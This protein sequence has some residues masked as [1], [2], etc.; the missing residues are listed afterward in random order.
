MV[1][2]WIAAQ[3]AVFANCAG[4]PLV[5]PQLPSSASAI[6]RADYEYQTAAAYFY[7]TEYAEAARRFRQIALTQSSPW[8]RYGHYLAARAMIRHATVPDRSEAERDKLLE[9]AEAQLQEVLRDDS[10]AALHD[11]A[12]GLLGFVRARIRMT[13]RL[14]ELLRKLEREPTATRQDVE[15]YRWLSTRVPAGSAAAID[16]KSSDLADWMTTLQA[17]GDEAFGHALERW[18]ETTSTAWLVSALW[19]A[20]PGHQTVPQMMS[21]AA[22]ISRQS[23]AFATV[24]FLRVRL[25]LARGERQQARVLLATLPT[26][27]QPGFPEESINL[28]RAARMQLAATLDELLTNSVRTIVDPSLSPTGNHLLEDDAARVLTYQLPL[29]RLVDASRSKALPQRARFRIAVAALSRALVLRRDAEAREAAAVVSEVA[30]PF[31]DDIS[32]YL[33]AAGE[34][35]RHRLGLLLM[36]RHVGMHAYVPGRRDFGSSLLND[37]LSEDFVGSWWC[38]IG[39]GQLKPREFENKSGIEAVFLP[40][41]GDTAPAFLTASEQAAA[42]NEIASLV[43]LGQPQGYLA[44]EAIRWAEAAPQDVRAAEA[45]ASVVRRG[46]WSCSVPASSRRAFQ[47]LHRLFPNTVWAQ[48]TKYWYTGHQ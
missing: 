15:D 3:D 11:S 6:L 19:K 48:R 2:E 45:L 33:G 22:G 25:M 16:E 39:D 8:Q 13:E 46:R 32:R 29:R 10:A 1:V 14:A 26:R 43:K 23:P 40:A 28:L 41:K 7:A 44:E 17:D 21:A 31:R 4:G 24:A 20:Q 34:E 27:S 30:P 18:R 35:E 42:R 36:L 5:L 37:W 9:S 12:Q 38:T 47:T